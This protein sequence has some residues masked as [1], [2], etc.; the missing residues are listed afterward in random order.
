M[1]TIMVEKWRGDETKHTTYR[2]PYGERT[3][4]TRGMYV[5]QKG[6]R[7]RYGWISGVMN[8]EVYN[9]KEISRE[10]LERIIEAHNLVKVVKE[11]KPNSNSG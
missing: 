3:N 11:D 6:N 9:P 4:E 2:L 10:D 1:E 8:Y 5:E 7:Y